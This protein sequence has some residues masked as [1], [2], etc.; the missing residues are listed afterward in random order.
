MSVRFQP[1]DPSFLQDPYATYAEL[2]AESP[3]HRIRMGPIALLGLLR[4]FSAMRR[5]AGAPGLV[6]TAWQLRRARAQQEAHGGSSGGVGSLRRRLYAVSRHVDV[7]HVLR[8]PEIFSSRAMGGRDFRPP[9]GEPAPTDGSLI[10]LDPPEHTAHRAIVNRGFTPR[11]MGELEPRIRK[12]ADELVAGFETRGECD[13]V[14]AFTNPLP[15]AVIAELLGLDPARRDDFK[16]WSTALI[17]GST[18]VG[19]TPQFELFR[20]FRQYMS[21]VAQE[22]D[23]NPGEDLISL[24]VHAQ[25]EEGVLDPEQVVGFASLL[26][27]AGSETT[28][29]LIG[30]ALLALQADPEQAAL[31]RADLGRIP[32]LL[33]ETLRYDSPIQLLMRVTER[34]TE[35][36]GVE[37]PE[38]SLVLVLL[39]AA[40]RDGEA[41]DQP[42]RFDIERNAQGHLA[43]GLGNHF[44]LGAS[45]ARLEARIALETLL[46]RCPD[47]RIA[48]QGRVERHGSFLVRGPVALPVRF[49]PAGR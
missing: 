2:R 11:R 10:G 22:R 36:G 19:A 39:G 44:C 38:G 1:F 31:V 13:L 16:R 18:Q 26:L 30:N 33:E 45:L 48:A 32:Q 3:V 34:A 7:T 27:A 12:L 49:R 37:L 46:T 21:A 29:N 28:T 6:R 5:A 35:L 47:L 20:E 8:H 9:G 40:N 25:A 14:K 41:F 24:L 4:R 42:D 43:F 23:R 17:I 15:V